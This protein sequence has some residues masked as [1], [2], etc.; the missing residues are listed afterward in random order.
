MPK[1]TGFIEP[2]KPQ[3]T[4]TDF[5]LKWGEPAYSLAE[6]ENVLTATIHNRVKNYG[7][8]FQRAAK[9]NITEELCG[10]T[11]QMLSDELNLSR[12]SIQQRIYK[13]NNPYITLRGTIESDESTHQP[14]KSRVEIWLMPEHPCYE[15]WVKEKAE[16]DAKL[17]A[18]AEDKLFTLKKEREEKK[19]KQE[20]KHRRNK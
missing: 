4:Q 1:K 3:E 10:K 12:V 18:E 2:E 8:P 16:A 11:M 5:E 13:F 17:R 7:S 15:E 14:Y 19:A 9:P 6:R 20:A